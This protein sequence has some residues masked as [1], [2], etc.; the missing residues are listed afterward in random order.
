MYETADIRKNLKVVID[1]APFVLPTENTVLRRSL[2]QW[3]DASGVR[4][5]IVGEFEDSALLMVF[6][7][8]GVGVFPASMAVAREVEEQYKVKAIGK[9]PNVRER[10]YAVTVERRIKHP[11]V[12]AIC[13]A[14]KSVI[15]A[16]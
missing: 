6:G 11:A 7:L 9:V 13:E 4:P 12:V 15:G 16:G 14:A 8:R 5:N 10:L 2:D 3:L 1:G